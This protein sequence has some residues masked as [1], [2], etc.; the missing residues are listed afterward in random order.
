MSLVHQSARITPDFDE[1][2]LPELLDEDEE[3]IVVLPSYFS[4]L[5]ANSLLMVVLPALPS[6][7]KPVCL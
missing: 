6:T 2:E 1:D 4:A 7:V 5:D 3:L